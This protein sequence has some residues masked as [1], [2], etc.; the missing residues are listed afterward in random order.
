MVIV[1]PGLPHLAVGHGAGQAAQA[2]QHIRQWPAHQRDAHERGDAERH[3]HR[4]TQGFF[5]IALDSLRPVAV[6]RPA[7]TAPMPRSAPAAW[8]LSANRE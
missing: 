3:A 5:L 8:G 1:M 4:H 2:E 7:A 6:M